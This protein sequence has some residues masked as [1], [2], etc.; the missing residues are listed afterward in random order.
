MADRF[1]LDA[2]SAQPGTLG[3]A[4]FVGFESRR[5]LA[6][7]VRLAPRGCGHPL[8]QSCDQADRCPHPLSVP[9]RAKGGIVAYITIE[10]DTDEG[11]WTL[12]ER[13]TP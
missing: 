13:V 7:A 6:R 1:D 3:L 12:K 10:T 5:R 8:R 4:L 11:R 2:C 9:S